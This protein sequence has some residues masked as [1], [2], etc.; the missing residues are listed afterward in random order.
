MSILLFSLSTINDDRPICLNIMRCTLSLPPPL[1][2]C[3][4]V[5]MLFNSVGHKIDGNYESWKY[6]GHKTARDRLAPG[7]GSFFSHPVVRRFC[8]CCSNN[9]HIFFHISYFLKTAGNTLVED[10]FLYNMI[11]WDLC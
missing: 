6:M 9:A 7:R 2:N 1:Y 10:I 3:N 4:T 5:A 8:W 11:I